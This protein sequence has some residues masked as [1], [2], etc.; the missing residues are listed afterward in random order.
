MA[1]A[2][3]KYDPATW[4]HEILLETENLEEAHNH[5]IDMIK[6]YG[7]YNIAKGG[8]GG[9]TGRNH[10]PE[11]IAKQA[12]VLSEHWKNLPEEEKLR[13]TKASMDTKIKNGTLGNNNPH[14]GKDH[15]MWRGYWVV[16]YIK[17]ETAREASEQS[18]ISVDIISNYCGRDVDKI[19]TRGSK[20]IDIGKTP[21]QQGY[22]KTNE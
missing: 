16:N 19:F 21:R 4:T 11:K 6:E 18:G 14:Y 5:E 9:N 8:S 3:R 10:E 7:Y 15:G 12:K 2:L 22:Y 20:I 17:Y 13:R 1:H